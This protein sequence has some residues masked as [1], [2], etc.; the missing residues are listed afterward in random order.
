MVVQ[1]ISGGAQ[2]ELSL[3]ALMQEVN[4]EVEQE[5]RDADEGSYG[6][7]ALSKKIHSKMASKGKRH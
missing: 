6:H 2:E 3:E 5:L 4:E 1:V 7:R